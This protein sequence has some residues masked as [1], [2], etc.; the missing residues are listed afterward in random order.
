V[1]SRDPE[2]IIQI[3]PLPKAMITEPPYI[4]ASTPNNVDI[5]RP[6]LISVAQQHSLSQQEW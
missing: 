3:T 2:D 6:S 4:M 1:T 5:E